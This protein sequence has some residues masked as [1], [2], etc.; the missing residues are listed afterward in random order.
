VT[1]R[2]VALAIGALVAVYLVLVGWRG[3]LLIGEGTPTTVFLGLAIIALPLLGAWVLW[4]EIQFGIESQQMARELE[5]EG[6]LPVDDVPRRPSGRPER[7]AADAAFE[8][9]R[10]AVEAAPDDWRSWFRLAIAYN[11]AGD[12]RRARQSMRQ[13]GMLRRG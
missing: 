13:A 10:A 8:K 5:V 2:R 7:L 4:R 3:V 6:G 9:R 1:A 11:D 12:R